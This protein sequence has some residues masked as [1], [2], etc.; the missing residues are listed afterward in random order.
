MAPLLKGPEVVQ[1]MLREADPSCGSQSVECNQR[2]ET[3]EW[4][5]YPASSENVKET[6]CQIGIA[7]EAE[8]LRIRKIDPRA[9]VGRESKTR[10]VVI[11]SELPTTRATPTMR[12]QRCSVA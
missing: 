6:N 9:L 12:S 3:R 10:R 1:D 7:D 8:N 4:S 11:D 5:P 2:H